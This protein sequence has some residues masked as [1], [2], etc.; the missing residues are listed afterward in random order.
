MNPM[1]MGGVR[2]SEYVSVKVSEFG[3]IRNIASQ[4]TEHCSFEWFYLPIT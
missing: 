2:E 3:V 1:N 4:R